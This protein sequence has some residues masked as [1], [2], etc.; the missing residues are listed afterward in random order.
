M[1]L[2]QTAILEGFRAGLD[3][4]GRTI[5]VGSPDYKSARALF[6]EI[7]EIDPDFELVKD[8]REACRMHLEA[9]GPVIGPGDTILDGETPTAPDARWRVMQTGR[10]QNPNSP[11]IS[12]L[13]QKI[14]Q[15]S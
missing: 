10:S 15:T 13:I 3:V 14:I 7:S 4:A 5:W 11:L 8:M 1:T 6:E 2:G 12:Y 9:P